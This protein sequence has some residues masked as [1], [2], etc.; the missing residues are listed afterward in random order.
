MLAM[1]AQ[2]APDWWVN[3]MTWMPLSGIS[4]AMRRYAAT[5]L[6]RNASS[7]P[8]IARL[9]R[10]SH[11]QPANSGGGFLRSQAMK[12]SRISSYLTASP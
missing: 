10:L 1:S 7:S 8:W 3:M 12:N 6:R 5:M 2:I 9:R 4:S 11:T